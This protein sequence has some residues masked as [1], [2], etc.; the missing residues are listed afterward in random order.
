MIQI[1][2]GGDPDHCRKSGNTASGKM[3]TCFSRNPAQVNSL[4][5]ETSLTSLRHKSSIPKLLNVENNSLV[6]ACAS[7]KLDI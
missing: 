6:N 2:V 7:L 3:F 4:N 1:T 5:G